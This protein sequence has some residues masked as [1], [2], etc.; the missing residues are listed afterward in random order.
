MNYGVFIQWKVGQPL[1][2]IEVAWLYKRIDLEGTR[3]EGNG[4]EENQI[5]KECQHHYLKSGK[6]VATVLK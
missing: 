5:E 2:L 6:A 1:D 3:W 4:G